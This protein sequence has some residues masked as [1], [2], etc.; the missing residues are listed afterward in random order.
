MNQ[1]VALDQAYQQV[2]G[3]LVSDMNGEKVMLSIASSKYYNL[4]Q[5][6]GAIW[7]KLQSPATV[8]EV[9]AQLTEEYDIDREACEQQVVRFLESLL[10][11]GLVKAV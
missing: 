2:E 7:E 1:A 9:V 11:E 6:G 3:N 5:V 4:G 8:H 10:K